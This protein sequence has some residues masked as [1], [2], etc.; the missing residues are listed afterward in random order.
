MD[1]R[2]FSAMQTFTMPNGGVYYYEEV[3]SG[4]CKFFRASRTPSAFS[5]Q[6]L[7]F[8]CDE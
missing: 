5:I 8:V 4:E 2:N 3:P 6:P 7:A 1:L